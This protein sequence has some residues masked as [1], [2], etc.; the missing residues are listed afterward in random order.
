MT[1]NYLSVTEIPNLPLFG[2]DPISFGVNGKR[3]VLAPRGHGTWVI[4][5]GT[6]GVHATLT[7]ARGAYELSVA[8]PTIRHESGVSWQAV[9]S[10][11]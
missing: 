11:L 4:Q 2:G 6:S 5:G 10:S 8:A 1:Q 3:F 9:L 7:F